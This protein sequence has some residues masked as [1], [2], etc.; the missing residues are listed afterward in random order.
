[1][2]G[3]KP[4]HRKALCHPQR[5]H[6]AKGMCKQCYQKSRNALA[7]PKNGHGGLVRIKSPGWGCVE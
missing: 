3:S 6:Q 2:S 1:M 5:R 4:K 7:S